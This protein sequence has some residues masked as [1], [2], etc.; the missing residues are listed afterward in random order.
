MDVA[1]EGA[2]VAVRSTNA[3]WMTWIKFVHCPMAMATYTGCNYDRDRRANNENNETLCVLG[4]S[5]VNLL[6]GATS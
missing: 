5:A 3:G 1:L 4:V 6:H 2:S